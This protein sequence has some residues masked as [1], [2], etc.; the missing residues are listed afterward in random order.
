VDKQVANKN[1]AYFLFR[2]LVFPNISIFN[3][4]RVAGS[5]YR[6][7]K[8]EI[9]KYLSPQLLYHPR[10][11]YE[12]KFTVTFSITLNTIAS[13]SYKF[14]FLKPSNAIDHRFV[15]TRRFEFSKCFSVAR[16]RTPTVCK[17]DISKP[18]LGHGNLFLLYKC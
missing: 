11:R 1:K 9:S 6:L 2:Q 4:D 12:G 8:L 15:W 16:L 10:L 3:S 14:G 13:K 18:R 17:G 7:S 5:F